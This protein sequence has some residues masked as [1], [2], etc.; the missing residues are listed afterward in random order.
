MTT[1]EP[2]IPCIKCYRLLENTTEEGSNQPMRGLEFT[3]PGHY[4][5][6]VFD[7]GDGGH[8]IINICDECINDARDHRLVLYRRPSKKRV[9]VFPATVWT[10]KT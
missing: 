3:T 7:P 4:G 10:G 5:S 1:P 8:L 9:I 6:E 2:S